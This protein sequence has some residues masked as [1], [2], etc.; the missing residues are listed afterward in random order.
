MGTSSDWVNVTSGV[1]Q[2][3]V[4]GPTLLIIFVNDMP[5][6]INYILLMF[7]DD[8]KLYR[9]IDSSQDHNILQHNI[10][11]L[12]VW[13]GKSLMYFNLDKYHVMS[14]GKTCEVYNY[15]MKRAA[16]SLPMNRCDQGSIIYS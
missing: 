15:T 4:L 13:G 1:P 6:V 2:G 12:C 3:S 11:Q 7:A 9:T 5:N 8:T 16:I 10:D 14:F